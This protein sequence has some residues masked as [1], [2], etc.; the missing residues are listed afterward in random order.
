MN[1]LKKALVFQKKA[2]ELAELGYKEA[3]KK[4]YYTA[5]QY[6]SVASY[7]H[8]KGDTNSIQAQ[9][10]AFLNYRNA[11][12]QDET[13]LLKEILVPFQGKKLAA[14][15]TYLTMMPFTLLLLLVPV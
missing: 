13:G 9:A 7:P 10:L 8:L 6:Y 15:Y 2:N 4:A 1:G 14:I 5:S 3:A 12:K 11:F